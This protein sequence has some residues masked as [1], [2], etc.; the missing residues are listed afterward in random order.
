MPKI[1]IYALYN[2]VRHAKDHPERAG[3]YFMATAAIL[4]VLFFCRRFVFNVVAEKFPRTTQF[5][6]RLGALVGIIIIAGGAAFLL[7]ILY[8]FCSNLYGDLA[9]RQ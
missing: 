6:N 1:E 5:F 4:G 2:A 3:D 8:T 9:A 7:F